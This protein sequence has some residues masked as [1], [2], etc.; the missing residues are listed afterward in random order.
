M[1]SKSS[2]TFTYIIVG[3]VILFIVG[4]VF[5]KNKPV[6]TPANATALATC[7][8]N[9]GVTFYGASWCPH[10]KAQKE[11][12]GDAARLLPYVECAQDNGITPVCTAAGITG[13]PTWIN[14]TGEKLEGEQSFDALAKFGGCVLN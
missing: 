5:L 6:A 7:L 8:K 12:F 2:N 14:K 11:A 13:F 9:N 10:C 3:L 1:E 4:I